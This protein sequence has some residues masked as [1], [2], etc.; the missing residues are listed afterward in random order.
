MVPTG[1]ATVVD[2]TVDTAGTYLLVDHSLSRLDK[3]CVGLLKAEGD[4]HPEIIKL[5]K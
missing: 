2:F 4:E 5:V 1:G 3:G